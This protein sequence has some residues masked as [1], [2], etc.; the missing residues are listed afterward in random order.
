[1]AMNVR[2]DNWSWRAVLLGVL[3]IALVFSS[4]E[5]PRAVSPDLVISQV[6]GGGGNAGAPLRNDFVEL[7]NRGTTPASL[8]GLSI[9]Y[10][11]ATG[12]GAFGANSGQLTELPAVTLQPGQHF[13]VQEAGGTIGAP[14]PTA[15]YVD[16]TPINLS[17]SAGKVALVRSAT[18]LGCNGGSTPCSPAQ[19]ALIIDLVGYGG[20]NFSEGPAAPTLSNITAALRKGGGYVDTDNNAADFSAATPAPQNSTGPVTTNPSGVGAALPVIALPDQS[21]TLTVTASPG[22]NPASTGLAVRADLTSI[23]GVATQALFDDG[24]NGDA[25]AGDNV[26]TYIATIGKNAIGGWKSVPAAVSDAEGRS[27]TLTIKLGVEP[28]PI[29]IHDIQGQ[30]SL[31]PLAGELVVTTGVVTGVKTANGFFIQAPDNE[32]DGDPLTSEGIYVYTGS[33]MP[34][35]AVVGN[36]VNV[37]GTVQEYVPSAD[38]SSPSMTEIAPVRVAMLAEGTLPSAVTLTAADTDPAGGLEQLEKYEGMR[39]RVESLT[40]VGPTG[41]TLSEANA[42]STWSNG[43]FYGVITGVARPFREPGVQLP[44]P[45]LPGA[46]TGTPRFDGNPERLRVDSDALGAAALDVAAGDY[47]SEL[48]GPLDYGYRSY[49][50]DAD[51]GAVVTAGTNVVPVPVAGGG[52]FTIA[53][54][55]MQRFYDTTK[56]NGDVQLTP[57]AFERRL[58]KASLIIRNVMRM[59]DIIGVQEIENQTT[60]QLVADR[61]GADAVAA[62]QPDPGYVA[63]S[64]EGNDPSSIDVGFLVK[65]KVTVISVTQV[66][67]DTQFTDPAGRTLTLNDRPPLVLRAEIPPPNQGTPFP[68]TVIVNHLRSLGDVEANTDT[69]AF[70]RAKR[71]G[72]AEFLAGLI[73]ERQ[74]AGEHVVSVG[75]YNAYQFSDGYV[76]VMGGVRGMPAPVSEVMLAGSDLVNPDLTDLVDVVAPAQRY[77]YVEDGNAQ[78][79]DHILV[80]SNMLPQ[81]A[82]QAYARCNADFPESLRGDGARPERLSDHD[83]V[84]AYFNFPSADL[85]I[86]LN[87]GPN[88][89]LSGS[90]LTYTISVTNTASNAAVNVKVT[91][92]LPAGATVT[93][94]TPPAGWACSSGNPIECTTPSLS[95]GATAAIE[96]TAALA[97]EIADQSVLTNQVSVTA[98]TYDPDLTNNSAAFASTVLNTAPTITLKDAS[99]AVLWPVNHKLVNVTVD[100]D[101]TDNC[102]IPTCSLQV[103]SN[104]AANGKGDGNTAQD[105]IAVDEHHVQLRAERSG[106]GPGRVYTITVTC[107]DGKDNTSTATTQVLVPRDQKK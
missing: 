67:K 76:D 86:G 101:V 1:M 44:D 50:I 11:S 29:A 91:D 89:V 58:A 40:A 2:S 15:D 3:A 60:L 22:T 13:L 4:S 16:S 107:K 99:P 19:L 42:T 38:P 32:R 73:Q 21:M 55:N 5:Q 62:G 9:Q 94:V 51:A 30:G 47:I 90:T 74:S 98:A 84:V 83:P 106:T 80:S 82:A 104:E 70:A 24:T 53:T 92:T 88:P 59:P 78:V 79:L 26:F 97:C 100:Y 93:G 41:G 46:P 72:Q 20:T 54:F 36:L 34:A 65:T 33:A 31:S 69:G 81:V 103:T 85:A 14:L 56:N 75:D 27:G 43:V 87:A 105:W 71:L 49:T 68:V 28:A 23:G 64:E 96:I 61:I 8:A 6:Y 17:G 37:A 45:L 48:I 66:G 52:Q 39:V 95:G 35:A 102:A 77:S 63:Y 25:I 10:A 18:S 7:F 12:T 57:I